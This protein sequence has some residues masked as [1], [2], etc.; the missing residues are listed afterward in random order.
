MEMAKKTLLLVD[1]EDDVRNV[2]ALSLRDEG[3]EIG[4]ASGAVEALKML[5]QAPFDMVVSDYVMPVMNGL[6]LQRQIRKEFPDTLRIILTGR[7]DL[8]MAVT[9]M[10]EG[11]IHRFLVKPWDQVDL[12]INVRLGFDKL[13]L[14]RENRKLLATVKRQSDFIESLEKDHPGLVS[15]KRSGTGAVIVDDA[16]VLKRYAATLRTLPLPK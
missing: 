10:N 11:T 2:M 9:A 12:Q 3:Y 4:M 6:E 8:E 7:P 16:E 15:A 1:D 5:H 14:E 13:Q